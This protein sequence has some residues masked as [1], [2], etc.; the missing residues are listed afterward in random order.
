[1][2][3]LIFIFALALATEVSAQVNCPI[4]PKAKKQNTHFFSRTYT[5]LAV[6][7]GVYNGKIITNS[8]S[9]DPAYIG[10]FGIT[11]CIKTKVVTH[12]FLSFAHGDAIGTSEGLAIGGFFGIDYFFKEAFSGFGMGASVSGYGTSAHNALN[13]VYGKKDKKYF[14]S[15]YLG[16]GF[17]NKNYFFSIGMKIGVLVFK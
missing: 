10:S 8:M 6:Q 9:I 17:V 7:A 14:N 2:K 15:Y 5:T 13:L 11:Q 4:F 1:M 3:N 16:G 12:T